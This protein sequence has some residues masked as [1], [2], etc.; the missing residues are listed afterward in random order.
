V[1]INET[2]Y[3]PAW[4]NGTN[5]GKAMAL[6]LLVLTLDD[7]V[8][9]H[10][11]QH[12]D[13][14]DGVRPERTDAIGVIGARHADAPA[15]ALAGTFARLRHE[16]RSARGELARGQVEARMRACEQSFIAAC[17]QGHLQI[18]QQ[19]LAWLEDADRNGM[20]LALGSM[21]SSRM[22]CAWMESV[23][24]QDWADRFAV[25]ATSDALSAHEAE[26]E[27][28]RL[29][30]RTTAIPAHQTL[31]VT[32]SEHCEAIARGIGMQTVRL[33]AQASA[34]ESSLDGIDAKWLTCDSL[35]R[36]RGVRTLATAVG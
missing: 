31:L 32:A 35:G 11:D 1:T 30:L 2:Q 33:N 21:L 16:A 3:T 25:V 17:A 6:E 12:E 26:D 22:V 15:Q 13:H 18:R 36:S 5:K 28:Y 8:S 34:I 19:A 20:R 9:W 23:L 14:F 4:R 10:D 29:I 24:G 27:L 7:I